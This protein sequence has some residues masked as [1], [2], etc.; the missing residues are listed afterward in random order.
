M[1]KPRLSGE[2]FLD[3]PLETARYLADLHL[4][5]PTLAGALLHD[6]MEDCGVSF[7]ELEQQFGAEVATLV[8]AVTK[9]GRMDKQDAQEHDGAALD[10]DD[11]PTTKP[12]VSERCW[13]PWPRMCALCSSSWRTGFTTCA[14]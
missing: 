13:C 14:R 10:L 9:L 11:G 1:G 2:P 5:A 8:D 6:V 12:P 3:H 7:E 4:D